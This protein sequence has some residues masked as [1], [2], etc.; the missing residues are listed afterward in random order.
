M[1]ASR[2]G[3]GPATARLATL[4]VPEV[5]GRVCAATLESRCRTW[6]DSLPSCATSTCIFCKLFDGARHDSGDPIKWGEA[7]INHYL[8]NRVDPKTKSPVFSDGLTL[9][10]AI[11]IAKHFQGRAKT[12]FGIGTNLTNDLSYAC[13]GAQDGALRGATGGQTIRHTGKN[14][15]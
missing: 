7:I 11:E 13:S 5:G 2:T 3:T 14:D 4:G 9:P 6:R 12:A 8:A 10:R 15:V 1:A